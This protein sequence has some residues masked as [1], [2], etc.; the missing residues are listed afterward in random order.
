[1]VTNS[2]HQRFP[3][4]LSCILLLPS[5]KAVSFSSSLIWARL[6]TLLAVINRMWL[7][8]HSYTSESRPNRTG[9]FHFLSLRT[10]RPPCCEVTK[11]A[12][13]AGH[14]E[15]NYGVPADT[16]AQRPADCSCLSDHTWDQHRTSQCIAS[17][18]KNNCHC[19]K[20]LSFGVVSFTEKG[21]RNDQLTF[22]IWT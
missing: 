15:E 14:M 22:L 17:W 13:W 3:V 18:E 9:N 1:M 12:I 21:I 16:S 7:K 4:P 20:P 8:W 2:G 19:V 5:Q 11:V 6:V 10:H